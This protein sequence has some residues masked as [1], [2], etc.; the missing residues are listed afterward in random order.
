MNFEVFNID[1]QP[2][3]F[4]HMKEVVTA[5]LHTIIF[6]RAFGEVIPITQDCRYLSSSYVACKD[7]AIAAGV[8]EK[9]ERFCQ[10][11]ARGPFSQDEKRGQL[12]I[13]FHDKRQRTTMFGFQKTEVAVWEEWVIAVRLLN[14]PDEEHPA[15]SQ[16]AEADLIRAVTYIIRI[17]NTKHEHVPR[18]TTTAT[19]FPFEITIPKDQDAEA[20]GGFDIVKRMFSESSTPFLT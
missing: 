5:V 16:Q 20:W 8:E 12:V 1:L 19:T 14:L 10:G 13:Q 11:M 2:L 15:F 4:H 3:P 7:D 17:A 6:H 9:V 18:V